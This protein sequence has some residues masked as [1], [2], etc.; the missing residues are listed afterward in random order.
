VTPSPSNTS[1]TH[2]IRPHS[3]FIS[4]ERTVVLGSAEKYSL[5]PNNLLISA[6]FAYTSAA[7]AEVAAL[8]RAGQIRPAPLIT[9]RFPLEAY[10]QAYEVL[11][12]G[13]GPRGK[14]M[15]DI[16]PEEGS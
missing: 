5:D 3:F 12:S 2:L 7:F 1:P 14:V 15:L 16:R 11:R 10:E 13:S 8:L 4:A 6:S 9:H